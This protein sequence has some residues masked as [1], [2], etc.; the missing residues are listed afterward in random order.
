MF[1]LR[2][3]PKGRPWV[4]CLVYQ[5]ENN[6]REAIKIPGTKLYDWNIKSKVNIR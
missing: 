5:G 6:I 4:K 2:Q 1:Q 3:K